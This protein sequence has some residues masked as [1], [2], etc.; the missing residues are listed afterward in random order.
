VKPVCCSVRL[1]E[2]PRVLR[3]HGS[4]R[5]G[6]EE[7]EGGGSVR[8]CGQCHVVRCRL[9]SLTLSVSLSFLWY[10]ILCMIAALILFAYFVFFFFLSDVLLP[11]RS[12]SHQRERALSLCA[13]ALFPC[14]SSIYTDVLRLRAAALVAC[15]GDGR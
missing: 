10:S 5:R 13:S 7:E 9:L 14:C 3:V 2:A 6:E 4:T 15:F 11:S 8:H 12:S 1:I